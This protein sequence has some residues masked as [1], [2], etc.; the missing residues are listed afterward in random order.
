[1]FRDTVDRCSE[2][3]RPQLGIDLRAVLYP[4]A[5]ARAERERELLQTRVTQPAL[6]VVEYAL[7]RLWMSLGIEPAAMIGHSVGEYVAACLAQV[8]SLE[9]ALALVADRGRMMGQLPAGAMLAVPLDEAALPPLLGAELAIAAVNGPGLCVVSGPAAEI[10]RMEVELAARGIAP[11][12][13]ATSHAFHSAL[14]DPILEP[15]ARRVGAV[16]L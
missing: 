6:F 10:E 7:A 4:E 1:V 16:S 13:L 5:D 15:F 3:L 9:D 11:R 8:L 14:M 12:R 2:A